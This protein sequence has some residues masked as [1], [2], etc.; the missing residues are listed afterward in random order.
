MF[1]PFR[2]NI[3]PGFVF[4]ILVISFA[5]I[6]V[7]VRGAAELTS[8][9]IHSGGQ[10]GGQVLKRLQVGLQVLTPPVKRRGRRPSL[11][12]PFG[13]KSF[14]LREVYCFPNPVRDGDVPTIHVETG[15]ADAVGLT[16][17]DL[18]GDVVHRVEVTGAPSLINDGQGLEYAYE[19][20]WNGSIP[21]GAYLCR[22]VARKSGEND[23]VRIIKLAVIQ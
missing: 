10:G 23:L 5:T 21:S 18:A 22:I 9:S 11:S 14:S 16:F 15:V 19:Y 7:S 17:Y 1:H 8:F 20:R 6:P 12:D 2:H 3:L 13:E 4:L